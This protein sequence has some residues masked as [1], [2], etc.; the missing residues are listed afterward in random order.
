LFLNKESHYGEFVREFHFTL[1]KLHEI[2][3]RDNVE[4]L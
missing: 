4:I 2:H 1:C 3:W